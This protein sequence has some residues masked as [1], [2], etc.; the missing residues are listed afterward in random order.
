MR[1]EPRRLISLR[2]VHRSPE[3]RQ[4]AVR[5]LVLAL[6]TL[7]AV[8]VVVLLCVV[9]FGTSQSATSAGTITTRLSVF[10]ENPGPVTVIVGARFAARG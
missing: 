1:M 4:V 7:W 5:W 3:C 6:A 10:H 9:P 8:A 2:L